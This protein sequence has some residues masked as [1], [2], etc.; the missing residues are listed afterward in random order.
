MVWMRLTALAGLFAVSMLA[1]VQ[2][3]GPARGGKGKKEPTFKGVITHIH[4]GKGKGETITVRG[5][6]EHR[7]T[8]KKVGQKG[9]NRGHTMTFHVGPGTLI[10]HAGGNGG[11]KVALKPGNKGGKGHH[12]LRVGDI[13]EVAHIGHQ[14]VAVLVEG[15]VNK[16]A[17]GKPGLKNKK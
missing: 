14:A 3:A 5:H 4:H 13:V 9:G 6:E 16:A 12:H 8:G 15:H 17:K 10:R 11:N 2:A 1:D 7:R